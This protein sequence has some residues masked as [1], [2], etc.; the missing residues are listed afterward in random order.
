MEALKAARLCTCIVFPGPS[1]VVS[2]S[3]E[4]AGIMYKFFALE[5]YMHSLSYC[6]GYILILVLITAALWSL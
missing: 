2:F 4:Q 5:S 3:Y 1:L 6:G